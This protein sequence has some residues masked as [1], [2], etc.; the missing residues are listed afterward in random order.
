MKIRK[1]KNGTMTESDRIEIA[2]L[3]VKAGYTVRIVRERPAGKTAG[4]YEH[5][6]EFSEKEGV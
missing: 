5:F 1:L 6:I 4:A 3:L 2:R